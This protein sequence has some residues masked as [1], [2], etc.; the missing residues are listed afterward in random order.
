MA[1]G[2]PAVQTNPIVRT[3]GASSVH[4]PAQLVVIGPLLQCFHA[5]HQ[6]RCQPRICRC[7]ILQGGP[8]CLTSVS[9]A[10]Q[11]DQQPSSGSN[12]PLSLLDKSSAAATTAPSTGSTL[13]SMEADSDTLTITSGNKVGTSHLPEQLHELNLPLHSY[14]SVVVARRA[15][16][17]VSQSCVS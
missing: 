9:D 12:P 7:C 10:E 11:K 14:H 8:A 1:S 6:L 17:W 4:C 3:Q 16:R 13:L 2:P 5:V 15:G